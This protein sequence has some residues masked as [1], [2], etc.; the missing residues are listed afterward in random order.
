[1]SITTFFEIPNPKISTMAANICRTYLKREIGLSTDEQ[2]NAV[3]AEGISDLGSFALF[4]KDD[5]K[6]LCS[7][8]R[9]P[10]GT[11]PDPNATV[12]VGATRPTISNPGFRI[13]A[14]CESRLIDAA[15][16]ATLY[17][18]IGRP[19]TEATLAAALIREFRI[20]RQ[21]VKDHKEPDSIKSISKS[22][23][24]MKAL[25]QLP[26]YLREVIGVQG[27]A[28]SY[29]I[30]ENPTPGNV[31]ALAANKATSANY[32]SIM[33]ELIDHC[34]HI[35]AGFAEDNA[36]VLQVIVEMTKDTSHASSVKP[37]VSKRD[38]RAAYLALTQHNMGNS[39]FE[40]L[41]N[42][43]EQMV[44]TRIWNGKNARY[45]LK[46]HICR[47]RD[48][49]NDMVRASQNITYAL[50]EGRTRVSRLLASLATTEPN[51][52]SAKTQI[53]SNAILMGSFEDAA[54][55]LLLVNPKRSHEP[56]TGHRISA[57]NTGDRKRKSG[58]RDKNCE[59]G[60]SGVSLRYHKVHEYK[61][62]SEEQKQELKE[63][64]AKQNE[65]KTQLVSQ[66]ETL[67]QQI[68]ALKS[69]F[70]D[71]KDDAKEPKSKKKKSNPLKPPARFNQR[72]G[73]TGDDSD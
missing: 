45:S 11:I 36:A 5:I 10:G 46:Q 73:D 33:D 51:I 32:S 64:R 16:T 17:D 3:M 63:W 68:S 6:T 55:L 2:A 22:F 59:R 23:T 71:S 62:L 9:K 47:H 29:V 30:R 21:L 60:R 57:V 14:I 69:K 65:A 28:L 38:G 72:N 48:A 39:K 13:P 18:M 24:I 50:P 58:N 25:D 44:L 4:S 66:V 54:E 12:A 8:V 43:A 37:H 56:R 70:N 27:V 61:K 31:P 20:H 67:T 15:Y 34:P 42:A 19:I 41:V 7:S 26:G 35:G 53:L 49:Y 40:E 1:M 52:V